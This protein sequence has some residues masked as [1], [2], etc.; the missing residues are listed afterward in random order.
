MSEI[1]VISVKNITKEYRSNVISGFRRNKKPTIVFKDASFNI[2][3]NTIVGIYGV[4]GSGKTTL[5]KLLSALYLPIKGQIFVS[6]YAT[7]QFNKLAKMQV[8]TSFNNERAFFWKMTGQ[9]NVDFFSTLNGISHNKD[10]RKNVEKLLLLLG[11]GNIFSKRV[12]SYSAGMKEK[13]GYLLSLL[14]PKDVLIYDDFAKNLDTESLDKLW[15]YLR[16]RLDSGTCKA[17]VISSPKLVFL[18]TLVDRCIVIEKCK[19]KEIS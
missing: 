7:N 1:P 3:E 11:I 17:I 2:N 16:K 18:E 13:L 14:T 6:G 12:E 15:I 5:L 8:A 10:Y 9:E 4:N 19:L